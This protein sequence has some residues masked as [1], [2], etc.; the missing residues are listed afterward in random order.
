M[1]EGIWG[2]LTDYTS[3]V[4]ALFMLFAPV[5]FAIGVGHAFMK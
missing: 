2:L 1:T 3:R 5:V 4:I